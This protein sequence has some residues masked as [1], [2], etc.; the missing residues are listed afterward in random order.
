MSSTSE[1]ERDSDDGVEILSVADDAMFSEY[2]P[3]TTDQERGANNEMLISIDIIG[4]EFAN[5]EDAKSFF[6]VLSS[7]VF[8]MRRSK[9]RGQTYYKDMLQG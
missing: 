8:R 2:G 3:T 7:E 5:E 9:V 1:S 6:R 4:K